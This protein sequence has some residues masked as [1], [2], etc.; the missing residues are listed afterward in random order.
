MPLC[1]LGLGSMNSPACLVLGSINAATCVAAQILA[2]MRSSGKRKNSLWR[3]VCEQSANW[4]PQQDLIDDQCL[5]DVWHRE[6][7]LDWKSTTPD[8]DLYGGGDADLLPFPN[9]VHAVGQGECG[10]MLVTQADARLWFLVLG[11]HTEFLAW[12]S[13]SNP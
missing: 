4:K 13:T 8:T 9:M 11:A 12:S 2:W 3:R 1:V 7:Q 5:Y 6:E 10:V